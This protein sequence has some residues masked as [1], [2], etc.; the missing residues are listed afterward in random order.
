M[1][2]AV[3]HTLSRTSII[4]PISALTAHRNIDIQCMTLSLSYLDHE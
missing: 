3:T 1:R 2:K 4:H